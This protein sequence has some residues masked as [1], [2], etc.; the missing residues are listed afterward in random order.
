MWSYLEKK[1]TPPPVKIQDDSYSFH[2]AEFVY[3][4]QIDLLPTS[5]R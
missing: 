5:V 3:D 2:I 1:G 4:N